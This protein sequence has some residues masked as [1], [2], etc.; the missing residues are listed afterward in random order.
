[1]SEYNSNESNSV[2]FWAKYGKGSVKRRWDQGKMLR[3]PKELFLIGVSNVEYTS[4]PG[5]S[6][7]RLLN[8]E[9][10]KPGSILRGSLRPVDLDED[11]NYTAL[12]YTWKQDPTLWQATISMAKDGIKHFLRGERVK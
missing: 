10:G 12:S 3:K 5:P 4:L 9:P 8:I 11:P 6:W 7:I 1:M 2:K